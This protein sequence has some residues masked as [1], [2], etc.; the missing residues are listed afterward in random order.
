VETRLSIHQLLLLAE[1]VTT[2]YFAGLVEP[3]P[4]ATGKPTWTL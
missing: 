4:L 1:A 2:E 3:I